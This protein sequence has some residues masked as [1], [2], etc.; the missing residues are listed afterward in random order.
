MADAAPATYVNA[1]AVSTF[2]VSAISLSYSS[3]VLP[4]I[5]TA[6]L[7][8]LNSTGSVMIWKSTARE[9]A[10]IPRLSRSAEKQQSD[11]YERP[12][13]RASEIRHGH[14]RSPQGER[15]IPLR[16]LHRMSA[17]MGGNSDRRHGRRIVCRVGQP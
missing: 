16:M 11:Q 8:A 6:L 1:A 3:P 13:D 17:L 7:D 2:F 15:R 5:L 10:M 14:E 4:S 9:N 12:G